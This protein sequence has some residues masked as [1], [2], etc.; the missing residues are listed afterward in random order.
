MAVF[1]FLF[2]KE[3]GSFDFWVMS[4]TSDARWGTCPAA[5]GGRKRR[6]NV[7]RSGRKNQAG[8]QRADFFGDRKAARSDNPEVG[9]RDP[10]S[11]TKTPHQTV[12]VFFFACERR[13]AFY[14]LDK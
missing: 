10:P 14:E 13:L 5:A 6:G 2:V 11:A 9:G 12:W 1:L 7:H 8:E 3:D 4:P